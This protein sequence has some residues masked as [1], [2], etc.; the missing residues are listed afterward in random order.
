MPQRYCYHVHPYG[1]R[2]W[3]LGSGKKPP[4]QISRV[5]ETTPSYPTSHHRKPTPCQRHQHLYPH[6]SLRKIVHPNGTQWPHE[7]THRRTE[8]RLVFGYC[9]RTHVRV[10]PRELLRCQHRR[11]SYLQQSHQTLY[12]Q[13]FLKIPPISTFW[14][15][16]I[17]Q[18]AA[19][20]QFNHDLCQGGSK[21]KR[22]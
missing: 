16:G 22:Q 13:M 14:T 18:I 10:R 6:R 15:R 20:E 7:P 9:H 1:S 2:V 11:H 5:F 8:N 21:T 4:R 17:C 19:H 12:S 3:W